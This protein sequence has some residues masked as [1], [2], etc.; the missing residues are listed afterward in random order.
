MSGIAPLVVVMRRRRLLRCQQLRT[1][2]MR[3][4]ATG[5]QLARWDVLGPTPLLLTRQ[6]QL[7]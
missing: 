3:P 5:L 4:L 1:W 2:L 7:Q 6:H